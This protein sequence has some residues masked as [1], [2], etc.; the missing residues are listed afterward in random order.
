MTTQAKTKPAS[1]MKAMKAMTTSGMRAGD[2]MRLG[3]QASS[4][5]A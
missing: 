4:M 2:F 3:L 1:M 5:A